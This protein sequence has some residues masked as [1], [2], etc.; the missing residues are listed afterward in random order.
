MGKWYVSKQWQ[1]HFD[2]SDLSEKIGTEKS[3]YRYIFNNL[4]NINIVLD[5]MDQIKWLGVYQI[6][7][8]QERCNRN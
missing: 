6:D 7:S 3:K 5:A 2:I 1:Y 8:N 4:W